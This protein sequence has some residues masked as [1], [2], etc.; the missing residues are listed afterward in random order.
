MDKS[1]KKPHDGRIILTDHSHELVTMPRGFSMEKLERAAARAREMD[2][3]ENTWR[4]LP[5][6][7]TIILTDED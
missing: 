3:V 5:L 7:R 2:E 4:G 1:S 6:K